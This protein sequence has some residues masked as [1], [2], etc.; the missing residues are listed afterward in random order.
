MGW[1][2]AELLSRI[3]AHKPINL[4]VVFIVFIIC[5]NKINQSQEESN[6]VSEQ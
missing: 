6:C 1:N 3:A 4:K 5:L 2:Y